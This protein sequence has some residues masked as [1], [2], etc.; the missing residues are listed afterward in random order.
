MT[1]RRLA[2][3]AIETLAAGRPRILGAVL[4]R[5]DVSRNKYYYARHYGY[6]NRYLAAGRRKA[7]TTSGSI[8][9][10]GRVIRR[11]SPSW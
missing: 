10:T 8:Q 4:N 6:G 9:Y 7:A 1:R 5:V 3:R 2:E 11:Q